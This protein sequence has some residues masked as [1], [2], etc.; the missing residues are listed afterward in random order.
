MKTIKNFYILY[1]L[2]F[3]SN[4]LAN[5]YLNLYFK[6]I[7]LTGANISIIV[8]ISGIG[9]IISQPLIGMLSDRSKNKN[10]ILL[11]ITLFSGIFFY[12]IKL[13][14]NYV[15][16]IIINFIFWFFYYSIQPLL[17]SITMDFLNDKEDYGRIRVFGTIGAAI[18][19]LIY[20]FM[21]STDYM[22]FIFLCICIF[23]IFFI[24][25]LPKFS[26]ANG[27][28]QKNIFKGVFNNL[29]IILFVIFASI[30]NL[31]I[32][33]FTSF[34]GIYFTQDLGGSLGMYSLSVFLFIIFEIPF[35]VFGNKII[36]RLG[37]FKVLSILGLVT[38]SRWGLTYFFTNLYL[39]ILVQFLHGFS[40]AFL[41]IIMNI[42][43]EKS[44]DEKYRTSAQ[45][46]YVMCVLIASKIFGS[47][48]GGFLGDF[49]GLRNVFFLLFIIS[50]IN[51]LIFIFVYKKF[52]KKKCGRNFI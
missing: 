47:L 30:I 49:I 28:G 38:I 3:M 13:N 36:E 18:M 12:V 1:I 43:L 35:L 26:G 48:I 45:S 23:M 25:K 14:N 34:Y 29:E 21:N 15:Y 6:D 11:Y 7:G 8:A 32:G 4:N 19:A 41:F 20:I 9:T 27:K 52:C 50:I 17:T 39:Q 46:L 2:L 31:T 37:F 5:Q 24:R 10:R 16:L 22:F 40:F 42:Y 51:L 44:V 33:T